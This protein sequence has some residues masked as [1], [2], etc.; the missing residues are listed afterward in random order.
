VLIGDIGRERGKA[1][2]TGEETF[3]STPQGSVYK[4]DMDFSV[5]G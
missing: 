2:I 5:I 1:V 3:S 4:T